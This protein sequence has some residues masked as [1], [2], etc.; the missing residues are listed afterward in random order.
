MTA[1]LK[2]KST[3]SKT[4]VWLYRGFRGLGGSGLRG[5]EGVRFRVLG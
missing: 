4:T 2:K 5:P 1:L 3:H